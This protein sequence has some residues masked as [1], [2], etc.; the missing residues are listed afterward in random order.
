MWSKCDQ[1]RP[2]SGVDRA[3]PT[4]SDLGPHTPNFDPTRLGIDHRWPGVPPGIGQIQPEIDQTRPNLARKRPTVGLAR[5]RPKFGPEPASTGLNSSTS[6]SLDR[7]SPTSAR[8]RPILTG[9]DQTSP[10]FGQDWPEFGQL[11]PSGM[12]PRGARGAAPWRCAFSQLPIAIGRLRTQQQPARF[13]PKSAKFGPNSAKLGDNRPGSTKH[14][15]ETTAC[16]I[17]RGAGGDI[18]SSACCWTPGEWLGQLWRSTQA[19][20]SGRQLNAGAGSVRLGARGATQRSLS[21]LAARVDR[22]SGPP[23][24]TARVDRKS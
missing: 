21:G 19:A 15:P 9:F 8:I 2:Q 17:E 3:W 12:L 23:D 4:S 18:S 14:V 6:A 10:G 16:A 13:R 24:L 5:T 7:D 1:H 20:N 11:W 22:Q